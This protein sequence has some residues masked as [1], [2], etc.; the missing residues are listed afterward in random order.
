V[1][2]FAASESRPHDAGSLDEAEVLVIGGTSG[3]GYEVAKQTLARGAHVTIVGRSQTRLESALAGLR[4]PGA[5]SDRTISGRALDATAPGALRTLFADLDNVDHV[6]STLGGA[7]GGGFMDNSDAA[8]LGA[9]NGKFEAGLSVAKAAAGHMREGGS[10]TLTAGSG[11]HPYDASGAVVGNTAVELL[12]Q[13]LAVEMAPKIRVNAIAPFWTPTG[14][15][16]DLP[17]DELKRQTEA[18]ASSVPLK[19]VARVEEVAAAYLFAM[20]CGYFT[21]QT[22]HIDGGVS[23]LG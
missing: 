9:V 14:L 15:W 21:G 20:E 11:G 5:A 1:R 7:M 13:G 2:S 17:A 16:R 10:I 8:I 18:V 22:L 12:V 3:F 6:I 4:S 19:R 23:A